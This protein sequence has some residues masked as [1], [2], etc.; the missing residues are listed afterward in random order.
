MKLK[1]MSVTDKK[2]KQKTKEV[3]KRLIK[4]IDIEDIFK[5]EP[6]K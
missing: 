6:K 1:D 4:E 5:D 3:A 2:E